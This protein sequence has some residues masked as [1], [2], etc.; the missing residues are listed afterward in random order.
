MWKSP[1]EIL[2]I[3]HYP[4]YISLRDF[5]SNCADSLCMTSLWPQI[6]GFLRI[7]HWEW[8]E[9]IAGENIEELT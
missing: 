1:R 5:H 6:Y 4:V 3:P 8:S 2:V 7:V 9:D